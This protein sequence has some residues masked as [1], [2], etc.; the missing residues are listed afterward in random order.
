MTSL[1][2]W[3]SQR[4]SS[5]S[6]FWSCVQTL[7]WRFRFSAGVP[8]T[9]P[10][11]LEQL[12]QWYLIAQSLVHNIYI[13]IHIYIYKYNYISVQPVIWI[14]SLLWGYFFGLEPWGPP[15]QSKWDFPQRFL[16]WARAVALMPLHAEHHEAAVFL[17]SLEGLG[18]G[19]GG[20]KISLVSPAPSPGSPA[21]FS[22]SLL[23]RALLVHYRGGNEEDTCQHFSFLCSLCRVELGAC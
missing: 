1:G 18:H 11:G 20:L 2:E 15:L 12:V 16:S 3:P 14:Y 6:P 5:I 4:C 17:R 23:E 8:R 7:H 22:A 19:H 21:S 9:V 13:Y 10:S